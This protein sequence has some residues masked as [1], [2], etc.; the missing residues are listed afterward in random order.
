MNLNLD[1][2]TRIMYERIGGHVYLDVQLVFEG[3]TD[4]DRVNFIY[5]SGAYITVLARQIYEA[6]HLDR[7]PC[8]R[9]DVGGYIGK[10]SGVLFRIP[11]LRIGKRL[12]TG[13]WAFSP[14]REDL[15]QSLLGDNV[16]EYF[17]P[18]QDNQN[19]CFYFPDNNTP[20]PYTDDSGGFTLACDKVM[21][22]DDREE[23]L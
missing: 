12:L 17:R 10:T 18:V 14:D 7:L 15:E 9:V 20:N 8:R 19:D 3:S 21:Y 11:G 6:C 2:K 13:V 5:D 22:V 1:D 4:A 16:I 23:E